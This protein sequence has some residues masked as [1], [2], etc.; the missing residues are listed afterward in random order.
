MYPVDIVLIVLGGLFLVLFIIGLGM[1]I[2]QGRKGALGEGLLIAAFVCIGLYVFIGMPGAD[3]RDRFAG[4]WLGRSSSEDITY[5]EWRDRH[6]DA[7]D[8]YEACAKRHP[9]KS[10]K[11]CASCKRL[12]QVVQKIY[13]E[14]P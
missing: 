10:R 12:Y 9:E 14:R 5:D 1:A 11:D 3:N 13:E 4:T 7:V 2:G 8:R 6:H